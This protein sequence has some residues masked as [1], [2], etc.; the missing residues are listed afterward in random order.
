MPVLSISRSVW[1]D[2]LTE[3]AAPYLRP[4]HSVIEPAPTSQVWHGP[5][6]RRGTA[7]PVGAENPVTSRDLHVLVYEAAET[8][9]AQ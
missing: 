6:T 9:P 3:R 2:A 5:L 1:P 7:A 8:V 4:A